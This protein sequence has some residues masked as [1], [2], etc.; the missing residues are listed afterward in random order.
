[1]EFLSPECTSKNIALFIAIIS[2]NYGH[3]FF[4]WEIENVSKIENKCVNE[5]K[6]WPRMYTAVL[7]V[8]KLEKYGYLHFL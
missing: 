3:S 2:R 6:T 4:F 1:M 5:A 7:F 8:P